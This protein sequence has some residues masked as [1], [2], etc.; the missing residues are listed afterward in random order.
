MHVIYFKGKISYFPEDFVWMRYT[1]P[2]KN[3]TAAIFAEF[4]VSLQP[5][6]ITAVTAND[7]DLKRNEI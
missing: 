5:Y 1:S 2:N 6:D 4:F 7:N 3:K